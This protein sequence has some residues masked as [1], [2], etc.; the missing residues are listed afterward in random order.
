MINTGG[1]LSNEQIGLCDS[2]DF[3]KKNCT[4]HFHSMT[5]QEI[6]EM[7]KSCRTTTSRKIK[8]L[9]EQGYVERGCGDWQ[10][11]TYYITEK[12]LKLIKNEEEN[13]HA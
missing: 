3:E 4:N 11:Y 12:G 1:D 13:E 10:A 7:S 5:L 8:K 9:R 6:M 2:K